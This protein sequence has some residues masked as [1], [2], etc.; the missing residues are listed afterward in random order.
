[1]VD[2]STVYSGRD[3]LPLYEN[4]LGSEVSLT[5]VFQIARRITV[6]YRGDGYILSRAVVPAQQIQ[7]GVV[8]IDVV[9]GFVSGF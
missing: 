6:K 3:L 1:N 9:E 5:D 7:A 4:F 2:G 8:T